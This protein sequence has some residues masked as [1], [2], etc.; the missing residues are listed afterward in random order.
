MNEVK[1]LILDKTQFHVSNVNLKPENHGKKKRVNR[2]DIDGY[3][4]VPAEVL[5]EISRTT[6]E[7]LQDYLFNNEENPEDTGLE[8]L[9][10]KVQFNDHR[11]GVSATMGSKVTDFVTK[12]IHKIFAQPSHS[13]H[14]K[15]NM[16][17][18]IYPLNAKEMWALSQLGLEPHYIT[19]NP[20]PQQA[21][22]AESEEPEQPEDQE[23]EEEEE[24]E[25]T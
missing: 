25:T 22:L 8:G 9:P 6:T 23:E 16:Q 14:V 7:S 12:K 18:Q 19:I 11:L 15:I 5:N 13:K 3:V 4:E 1:A 10:F 20:P 17:I 2:M 24:E 21:Q